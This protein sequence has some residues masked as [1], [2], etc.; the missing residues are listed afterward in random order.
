MLFEPIRNENPND[1][2]MLSPK[3]V[4]VHVLEARVKELLAKGF[5]L[6][7]PSWSSSD[8]SIVPKPT[9]MVEETRS[10]NIFDKLEV[11]E[12]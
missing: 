11:I 3:G 9:E 7:D 1:P 10:V 5:T 12:I 8:G 6:V 2:W 4:R